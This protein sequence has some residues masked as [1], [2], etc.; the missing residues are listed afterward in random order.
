MGVSLP[1]FVFVGF[2]L[3][4]SYRGDDGSV[5]SDKK[6]AHEH[7]DY[8]GCDSPCG[9]LLFGLRAWRLLLGDLFHVGGGFGVALVAL[10]EL[11]G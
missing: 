5:K 4:L 1:R 9:L 3:L 2:L 11:E 10:F 8:D 7:G 6:H